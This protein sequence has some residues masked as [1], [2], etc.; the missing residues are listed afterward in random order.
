M[1][2]SALALTSIKCKSSSDSSVCV[3]ESIQNN[4]VC[5]EESIQNDSVC[6]DV[7]FVKFTDCS[8]W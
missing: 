7:S 3:D 2:L 6:V 4:S 8:L 1:L 5:V